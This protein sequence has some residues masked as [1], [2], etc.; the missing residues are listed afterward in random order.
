[1]APDFETT[2][3]HGQVARWHCQR[4]GGRKV[5]IILKRRDCPPDSGGQRD[6]EANPAR[7]GSH[8]ELLQLRNYSGRPTR[9]S[10]YSN[11]LWSDAILNSRIWNRLRSLQKSGWSPVAAADSFQTLSLPNHRTV[12]LQPAANIVKHTPGTCVCRFGNPVVHPFTIAPCRNNS[13]PA[14]VRQVPRNLWLARLQNLHKKTYAYL[15]V[16]NEVDQP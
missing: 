11:R 2:S 16:T 12:G 13:S 8:A 15:P 3:R 7:G 10:I 4:I 14:E 5:Q 9:P 1:M 6:R